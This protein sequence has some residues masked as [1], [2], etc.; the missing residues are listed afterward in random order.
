MKEHEPDVGQDLDAGWDDIEA[1]VTSVSVKGKAEDQVEVADLDAGW[2]F[3]E[4]K[5]QAKRSRQREKDGPKKLDPQKANPIA[6][7]SPEAISAPALTKK[8]RRELDRQ[9][10]IHASKRKS[11]AKALR[12]QERLAKKPAPAEPSLSS[13]ANTA[14]LASASSP[15]RNKKSIHKRRRVSQPQSELQP[16]SRASAERSGTARDPNRRR[17]SEPLTSPENSKPNSDSRHVPST[18]AQSAHVGNWRW[19]ALGI[20]LVMILWVVARWVFSEAR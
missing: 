5:P 6:S 12:K 18:G 14:P 20:A 4:P 3:D 11:E 10:Q 8:A 9:N 16:K 19:W 15:N 7:V 13:S 2:D 17:E 1:D